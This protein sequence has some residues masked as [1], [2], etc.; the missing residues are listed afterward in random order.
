MIRVKVVAGDRKAELRAER[1]TRLIAATY[2][3]EH[4]IYETAILSK[5]N[6]RALQYAEQFRKGLAS[7][8]GREKIRTAYRIVAVNS[9]RDFNRLAKAFGVN[10]RVVGFYDDVDD[11]IYC[12]RDRREKY[13]QNFVF[14][15]LHEIVHAYLTRRFPGKNM[16]YWIDEGLAEFFSNPVFHKKKNGKIYMDFGDANDA[17]SWLPRL[18]PRRIPKRFL[19]RRNFRCRSR[20]DY[21]AAAVVAG[22]I[23]HHRGGIR[24]LQKLVLENA[25]TSAIARTL[26]VKPSNIL[27]ELLDCFS[28]KFHR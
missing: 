6:F 24:A 1:R 20:T 2:S 23:L 8:F 7:I 11:T 22:I 15:L 16:R 10:E 5:V 12:Y 14:T 18:I 27:S 26:K 28:K 19:D 17:K 3:T 21:L 4:F 9:L 13:N 25:G